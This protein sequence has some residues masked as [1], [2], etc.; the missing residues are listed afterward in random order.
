[1]IILYTIT[2]VGMVWFIN[3]YN[4]L[5]G[6]DGYASFEA[7]TIGLAFYFFTGH[8]INLILIASVLWFSDL[9]LAQSQNF[10]G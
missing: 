1:M 4:F 10:H 2:I 3:L 9:E 5:D 6:I 7:I 8:S